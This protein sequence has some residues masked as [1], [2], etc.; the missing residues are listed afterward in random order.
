MGATTADMFARNGA[1]VIIGD[2]LV[3][4]G[5]EVAHKINRSGHECYFVR[6]DVSCKE[7][8][9]DAVDKAKSKFGGLNVL[10]NNAGI[11]VRGNVEET[12]VEDWHQVMKINAKGVFLGTKAAIPAMRDMGGGSIINLSS[13]AGLVG[14]SDTT[15]YNA[16]KAAV[17]LLTKSTALQY[18]KDGIRVNSIHPGTI[19]TPL[20]VDL[21]A[22]ETALQDRINRTPLGR[23]G[24]AE[25]VAYGIIYLASEESSYITGSELVI[26]G[27]RTAQ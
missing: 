15:V 17:R 6:L 21:Q 20:T 24:T 5:L 4:K 16:S 11:A 19:A 3:E 26:D 25:D 13:I 10:V 22:D 14:S 27:G 12:C 9:A 8:W 2:I 7:Q 23:L 18:A 1:K